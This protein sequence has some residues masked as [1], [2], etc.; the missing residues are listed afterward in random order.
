MKE[1]GICSRHKTR[2]TT[3]EICGNV[4]ER[5]TIIKARTNQKER[6]YS[7]GRRKVKEGQICVIFNEN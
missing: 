6:K 5:I 7:F 3:A 4:K 2:K 1:E